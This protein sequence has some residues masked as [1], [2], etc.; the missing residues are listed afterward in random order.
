MNISFWVLLCWNI[1]FN[2]FQSNLFWKIF[3]QEEFFDMTFFPYNTF[4]T[5]YK[6]GLIECIEADTV[7]NIIKK[8]N[9]IKNYLVKDKDSDQKKI[10]DNYFKS[11]GK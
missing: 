4:L 3:D 7:Q 8:H 5:G 11:C 1:L 2:F 6:S 10:L 9:S